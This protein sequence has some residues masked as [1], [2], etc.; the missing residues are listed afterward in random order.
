MKETKYDFSIVTRES[1]KAAVA[2]GMTPEDFLRESGMPSVQKLYN[3][4]RGLYQQKARAEKLIE[5]LKANRKKPVMAA[6]VEAPAEAEKTP[7]KGK[8]AADKPATAPVAE[9]PAQDITKPQNGAP[10]NPASDPKFVSKY[11]KRAANIAKTKGGVAGPDYVVNFPEI[12]KELAEA[13]KLVVPQMVLNN[14]RSLIKYGRVP[15]EVQETVDWLQEH[16]I[17]IEKAPADIVVV[18]SS[19]KPQ[20]VLMAK[21]VIN[22]RQ[23]MGD[24]WKEAIVLTKSYEV[25]NLLSDYEAAHKE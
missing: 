16:A 2:N 6:P 10:E 21:H 24:E 9:A 1:A 17:I 12:L 8:K 4:I 7:V 23:S 3:A 25:R 19:V 20:S 14:V 22:V 5:G 15:A 11:T 18:D 13:G